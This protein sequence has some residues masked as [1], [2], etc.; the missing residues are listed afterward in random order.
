[1]DIIK[2]YMT[3]G[4][5][6]CAAFI[7][8]ITEQ[9]IKAHDYP[10]DTCRFELA[11]AEALAACLCIQLKEAEA[12][13]AVSLKYPALSKSFSAIAEKDGRVRACMEEYSAGII[14]E[15]VIL[16]ITQRLPLRGDYTGIVT[17]PTVSD[18][19]SEYYK[20]SRQI[21]GFCALKEF[22]EGFVCVICERL[23]VTYVE[24][25]WRKKDAES[26]IVKIKEAFDEP[27]YNRCR[28]TLDQLQLISQ[29]S[30]TYG[31]TCTRRG[32]ARALA[33]MST[34]EL[35]SSADEHGSIEVIC[36]YCGRKYRFN[37]SE[38]V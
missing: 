17:A 16:E 22:N 30:L 26:V 18:A 7:N 33:L 36:K 6:V 20:S 38:I 4:T 24:D 27:S 19:V 1:M 34:E 28:E 11:A 10:K 9:T 37:L 3:P 14:T 32:L 31:C 21:E 5:R 25:E 8:D 29:T 2:Q 15:G 13:V 35:T 12:S 23:P